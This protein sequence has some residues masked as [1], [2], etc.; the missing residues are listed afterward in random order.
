MYVTRLARRQMEASGDADALRARGPGS[1]GSA[2]L[3]PDADTAGIVGAAGARHRGG[4]RHRMRH[5]L[6]AA[7]L[8]PACTRTRSPAAPPPVRAGVEAVNG[9]TLAYELRGRPGD[10]RPAVVLVHGGGFDRRLWDAQA[11][12]FDD[13]FTVLRYDARGFGGSG[14][15]DADSFAHHED[16]AALLARLGLTRVSVVGQSLG[17]RIAV[18]LAL[19][20]PGLV[21]RLVLVGPGL[22]GWPWARADFGPWA[23][24]FSAALRAGDTTRAVDAWLASDYMRSAAA[25]PELRDR[26]RRLAREN[27]RAWFEQTKEREL[28]PPAVGRLRELRVPVLLVLG[29][30]DE[31]PIHR[32]VDSLAA[33][34]PAARRLLFEGAGHAPNLEEPDRFN[35]E[36]LAFLRGR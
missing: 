28:A 14:R 32:I 1:P 17:G 20:H 24:D 35:R 11:E 5:L 36:V 27:A 6:L 3:S 2:L 8:L 16:L 7:A 10:G 13:D 21:E 29:S 22:S 25:R 12:S 34:V 15:A 4:M 9:T 31:R 18:D 19:T 30:T 33:A 23:A 26:L